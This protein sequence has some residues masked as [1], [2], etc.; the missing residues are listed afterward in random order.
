MEGAI[1]YS[2]HDGAIHGE[3]AASYVYNRLDGKWHVW[4][5]NG[6]AGHVLSYACFDYDVRFGVNIID[7]NPL[8]LMTAEN[9][10][11]RILL[12]KKGDEDPDFTYDE[13]RKKWL[14]ALC[15][16]DENDS[17]GVLTLAESVFVFTLIL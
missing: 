5:R 16:I 8:P 4:V 17:R 15:R 6:S 12:G 2:N 13:K 7:V 9:L 1:F 10:D 11:D 14:L 3:V